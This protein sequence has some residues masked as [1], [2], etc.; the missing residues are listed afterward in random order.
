MGWVSLA[1]LPNTEL[2]TSCT[3]SYKGFKSHFVKIR[4]TEAG[5][6]CIDPRPLPLYWREPSNFNGLVRSQL[7][8]ESKVDLQILD[9][10]SRRM[11]C[12]DIVSWIS[13]N[14]ATLRLK[15]EVTNE[16]RSANR[17]AS[18]VGMAVVAAQKVSVTAG[19]AKDFGPVADKM[20]TTSRSDKA[21]QSLAESGKVI[22]T[23]RPDFPPGGLSCFVAPPTAQS[24]WG[25]S[26][27]ARALF[28]TSRITQHDR[29]LLVS[30][31]VDN[32]FDMMTAY[33][34][35][36]MATLEV[37]RGLARK[38]EQIMA[39][40][41]INK[42]ELEKAQK[43]NI[44]SRA[45]VQ[46][47]REE[48]QRGKAEMEQLKAGF[49]SRAKVA[50]SEAEV[51]SLKAALAGIREDLSGA[52]SRVVEATLASSEEAEVRLEA[53]LEIARDN[54]IMSGPI[55]V[56]L[57]V[58]EGTS[59]PSLTP[60]VS[61]EE[62]F[63]WVGKERFDLEADKRLVVELELTMSLAHTRHKV[64]KETRHEA[65]KETRHGADR[66]TRHGVGRET[67]H[68]FGMKTQYEVGRET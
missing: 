26:F 48:G 68:E 45:A 33:M 4:A 50:S 1:P 38:V 47:L 28:P 56:P 63:E 57:A 9:S 66:K 46:K 29:G 25:A 21:Q 2:F 8:L 44:E 53:D 32:S 37:W 60:I 54:L 49:P 19:V 30:A 55:V 51:A 41:A 61:I 7:S 31:G 11:N 59:S 40:T 22:V 67:Q 17:E 65:D 36:S 13:S 35:C 12:K 62:P 52:R 6:F 15:S 16:A 27:D 43:A 24:L 23:S 3:T 34:A 10:L 20:S 5:H 39:K 42:K 58:V 14:N 64:D 18:N